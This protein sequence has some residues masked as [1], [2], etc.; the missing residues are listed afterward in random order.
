MVGFD[1]S[2][3]A[4]VDRSDDCESLAGCADADKGKLIAKHQCCSG[5]VHLCI[6]SL[7]N[8]STSTSVGNNCLVGKDGKEELKLR[9]E[10]GKRTRIRNDFAASEMEPVSEM[11]LETGRNSGCGETWGSNSDAENAVEY[12]HKNPNIILLA[13]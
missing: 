11:F 7:L 10:R 1:V 8:R 2:S 4:N 13:G 9:R 6:S 5:S 12:S 3:S